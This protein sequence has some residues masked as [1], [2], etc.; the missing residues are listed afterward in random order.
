MCVTRHNKS[1][2]WDRTNVFTQLETLS[3]SL[4]LSLPQTSILSHFYTHTHTNTN[5]YRHTLSLSL[6]HIHI[7]PLIHIH[8]HVYTCTHTHM[9]TFSITLTF[10]LLKPHWALTFGSFGVILCQDVETFLTKFWGSDMSMN[11]LEKCFTWKWIFY[12]W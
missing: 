8:S 9:H 10:L 6:A 5:K 4:P 12:F 1:S 7:L 11:L 2:S 3:L